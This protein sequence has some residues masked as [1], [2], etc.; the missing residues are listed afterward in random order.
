MQVRGAVEPSPGADA[1]D[2]G[3][4]R[5]GGSNEEEMKGMGREEEEEGCRRWGAPRVQTTSLHGGEL[6]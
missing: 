3:W 5:D 1:R 4:G 6:R 2:S